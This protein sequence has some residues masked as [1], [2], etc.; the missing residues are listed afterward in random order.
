MA[1]R[2]TRLH[3]AA[4]AIDLALQGGDSH[5][6]FAGGVLD[7]LLQD[8]RFVIDGRRVGIES[9]LDIKSTILAPR[10]AG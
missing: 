4:A 5:G 2:K 1:Y 8:S 9:M 6:A 3:P 10:R 7:R